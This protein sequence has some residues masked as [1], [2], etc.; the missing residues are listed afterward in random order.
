MP[1]ATFYATLAFPVDVIAGAIGRGFGLLGGIQTQMV[2]ALD[3]AVDITGAKGTK[4]R[5]Y[6]NVA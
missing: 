6:C 5:Q 3:C 2:A 4:R 1:L